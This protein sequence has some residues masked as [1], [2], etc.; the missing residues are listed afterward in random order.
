M[1]QQI[2]RAA[3]FAELLKQR[4]GTVTDRS[5]VV[6]GDLTIDAEILNVMAKGKPEPLQSIFLKD[7]V[8]MGSVSIRNISKSIVIQCSEF[9]GG[10]ILERNSCKGISISSTKSAF[11]NIW[12]CEVG[13][14]AISHVEI[15]G[16]LDLSGLHLAKELQLKD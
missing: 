1:K 14:V 2:M 6:K 8:F 15:E 10:L 9:S 4:S 3:E 11:V 13:T 16:S 5:I 12:G 7:I